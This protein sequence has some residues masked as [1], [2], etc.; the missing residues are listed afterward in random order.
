VSHGVH[1]ILLACISCLAIIIAVAPQAVASTD[2]VRIAFIPLD[3]RPAT[4]LF[5]QQVGAICGSQLELPPQRMLGHFTTPGDADALGRWLLDLDTRG[6]SAVVI[7]SD[8]LAYGGLVASRTPLTPIADARARLRVLTRF[9]ELHPALPVYVFGTIMRLAPTETPQSEPYLEPLTNY[10]RLAGVSHLTADD[11]AALAESRSKIPDRAFWDYIGARARD[12]ETD[13]QLITLAAKGDITWL[14]LTQDDA[15]SPDGLQTS[16]QRRLVALAAHLGVER[17]VLFNPGADEMGMVAITRAIEDASGWSPRVRIEY[18]SPR[19][20]QLQDPLEDVTVGQTIETLA[21]AL[22]MPVVATGQDFTLDVFTPLTPIEMRSY[23]F[24]H[25]A[26]RLYDGEPIAVADITFIDDDIGEER[27]TA[28][29]LQGAGVAALPMAFASWNTTANTAGTALSASACAA[30]ARHFGHAAPDAQTTFLF[31]R[32][33]DDY[34][35]RLLV[36]PGLN[37]DLRSAGLDTYALGDA[38]S[39]AESQVRHRLWPLAVDWFVANFAPAG[40]KQSELS[41]Y[42]P[43]QR[44]FEVQVDTTLMHAAP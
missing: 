32:Y 19:G 29:A 23:Y 35:F 13:E 6:L 16:E 31:D 12:L 44:T 43:W 17:H 28:E 11:R 21:R 7:S 34:A 39:Y 26:K 2:V 14:A 41:L 40:W 1:R 42:L 37:A 10:A 22:R 27:V 5:P 33:V 30:L 20:P 24:S 8:M 15:G 18:S 9:H 25:L 38:S 36:R 3:D 4:E